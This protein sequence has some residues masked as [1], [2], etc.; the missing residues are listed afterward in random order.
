V[1]SD[2]AAPVRSHSG[3]QVL[4]CIFQ[5]QGDS[6]S[7]NGDG[8][9]SV[10]AQPCETTAADPEVPIP[11]SNGMRTPKR[12]SVLPAVVLVL[13]L[14]SSRSQHIVFC[15]ANDTCGVHGHL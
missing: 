8:A 13:S 10:D 4:T 9:A 2:A 15:N 11:L 1:I 5:V 3:S 6:G 14:I 7:R 12:V